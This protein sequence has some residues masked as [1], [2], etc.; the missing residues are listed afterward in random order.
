MVNAGAIVVSSLIKVKVSSALVLV[1][2][3]GWSPLTVDTVQIKDIIISGLTSQMLEC[4][5]FGFGLA[6]SLNPLA[7]VFGKYDLAYCV[8]NSHCHIRGST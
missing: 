8:N 5:L 6:C 1:L 3:M 7:A 2:D 4:G